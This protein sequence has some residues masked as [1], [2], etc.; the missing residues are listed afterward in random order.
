MTG[1]GLLLARGRAAVAGW[2]KQAYTPGRPEQQG[3]KGEK[4]D[5]FFKTGFF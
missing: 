2:P 1:V 3:R 4:R 5:S